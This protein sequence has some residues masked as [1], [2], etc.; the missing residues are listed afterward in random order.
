VGRFTFSCDKPHKLRIVG[1]KTLVEK[2]KKT[3][4]CDEWWKKD[5]EG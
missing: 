1:E 4:M 3:K 5:K 2:K